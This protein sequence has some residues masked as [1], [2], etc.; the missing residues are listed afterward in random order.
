MKD[1]DNK[2]G[3][4]R[5]RASQP[6]NLEGDLENILRKLI[7]RLEHNEQKKALDKREKK[8]IIREFLSKENF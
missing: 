3:T 2:E 5:T 8:S 4:N 7:A 6:E 1:Q